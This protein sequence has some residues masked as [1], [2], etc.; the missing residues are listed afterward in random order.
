MISSLL[1]AISFFILGVLACPALI[2]LR[3]RKSNRWDDS[4][5][6]NIYRVVAYLA[7]HPQR[8]G[9]LRYLNGYQPFWYISKDEF[10]EVVNKEEA[11]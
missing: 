11:S 3:A 1:I 5:L 7:I 4:N 9:E 6:F 2:F 8:F 10:S